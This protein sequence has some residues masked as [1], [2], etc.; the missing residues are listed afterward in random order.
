MI[1][2]SLR[3]VA[4]ALLIGTATVAVT[5]LAVPQMAQAAGVRPEVG[6]PL[7]EAISLAKSGKGS[8]ALAEV[9]KAESVSHLTSDE[10]KLIEQ[11]K[12]YVSVRTGN[13]SGGVTSKTMAQAKI[14]ADYN[15][16]RYR[17]VVSTDQELLRKFGAL[18]FKYQMVIASAYYQS[19]DYRGALRYLSGMGDSTQVLSLRM[20]AAS[21]LGNKDIQ[22]DVAEKLVLRGQTKYWSYLFAAADNM[23]GFK[24]PQTLGVLRVRSLTGYMRSANDYSN[25]TQIAILLGFPQEALSIEQTGFD[26]KVL[27]DARQQRLL[28]KAQELATQQKKDLPS[29]AKQAHAD[30]TGDSLVNLGEIY[31]GIGRYQDAVDA[32]QAGLAKGGVKDTNHAQ[33]VLGMGYTG[34]KKTSL[35]VRA[36]RKVK[37]SKQQEE[38]ARLWSIYARSH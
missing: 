17:E 11:T 10:R 18:D 38:V 21:K 22:N 26:K 7:Q 30:K 27:S 23:S 25:A 1:A 15:A 34:L 29:I 20:G 13:F 5:G 16:R 36:F 19:G 37:N 31:W 2:K 4:A 32:V 8:A 14:S 33:I 3:G 6:K 9:R 24:Y 35:A 28:K 12:Q